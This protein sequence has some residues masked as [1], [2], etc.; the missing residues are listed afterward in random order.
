MAGIRA[1][2]FR[3]LASIIYGDS[4]FDSAVA[5]HLYSATRRK[6]RKFSDGCY[7]RWGIFYDDACVALE[8]SAA[9]IFSYALVILPT[10][11]L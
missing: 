6:W 7:E 1:R 9:D 10:G 4:T 11:G 2:K 5:I 3:A 8:S